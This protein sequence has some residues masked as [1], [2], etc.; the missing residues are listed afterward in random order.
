MNRPYGWCGAGLGGA[1]C[2]GNHPTRCAG[3]PPR[4]GNCLRCGRQRICGFA[5]RKFPSFGGAT[6]RKRDVWGGR[7]PTDEHSSPLRCVRRRKKPRS[8][9]IEARRSHMFN[10]AM[11]YC[12]IGRRTGYF[13]VRFIVMFVILVRLLSF[14][15]RFLRHEVDITTRRCRCQEFFMGFAQKP[16]VCAPTRAARYRGYH[17][18]AATCSRARRRRRRRRLG[19]FPRARCPSRHRI[20]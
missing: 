1:P 16:R 17:R 7:L 5:V 6:S 12:A 19:S 20:L 14:C 4:E 8:D 18:S 11:T 10:C 13:E 2:G 15:C 3:T 9:Y